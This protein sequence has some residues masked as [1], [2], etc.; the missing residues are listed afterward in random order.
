[1]RANGRKYQWKQKTLPGDNLK[2]SGTET[3]WN[4]VFVPQW[5]LLEG[6]L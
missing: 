1:M 4:R 6:N 2:Q 3:A 5:P